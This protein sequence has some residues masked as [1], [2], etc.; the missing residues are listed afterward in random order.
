[1][2]QLPRLNL[3][4]VA[5]FDFGA[6]EEGIGGNDRR[7]GLF[8]QSGRT[9]FRTGEADDLSVDRRSEK[10]VLAAFFRFFESFLGARYG[11]S[12]RFE[13]HKIRARPALQFNF[14]NIEIR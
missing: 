2:D 13:F 7:E 8:K 1:M 10:C 11:D 5:L 12:E 3:S 6:D 4:G 14:G 9:A